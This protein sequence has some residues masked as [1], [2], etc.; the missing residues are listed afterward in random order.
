MV[1]DLMK[2]AMIVVDKDLQ[3]QYQNAKILLYGDRKE[4]G[5]YGEILLIYNWQFL[6]KN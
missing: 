6:A 2:I 3:K 4:L 1:A 5:I